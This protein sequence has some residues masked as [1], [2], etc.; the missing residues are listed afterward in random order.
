MGTEAGHWY[1]DTGTSCHTQ[2]TATGKN[3]GRDRPTTLRDARKLNLLPSVTTVLSI[4]NKGALTS[5]LIDQAIMA[6]LTCPREEGETEKSWMYRVKNQDANETAR[7]AAEEGTRIHNVLEDHHNGKVVAPEDIPI[8][9]AVTHALKES[10]GDYGWIP[11]AACVNKELGY[12]GMVDIHSPDWIVDYKTKDGDLSNVRCYEDHF[13]QLAA[14]REALGYPDAQCAN[15][16][17]SR[18]TKLENGEPVVKVIIHKKEQ[19]Q[20]GWDEFEAILKTWQVIKKY[21]PDV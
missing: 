10:I 5:W 1:T 14:Y 13:R 16:F 8:V 17:I 15:V 2:I 6:A 7:A 3:A 11:E 18:D 21:K 4:M 20:Q 9:Y 19:S 12:A